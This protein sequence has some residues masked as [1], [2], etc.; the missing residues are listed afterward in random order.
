MEKTFA[1]VSGIRRKKIKS[2]ETISYAVGESVGPTQLLDASAN[3]HKL[4]PVP[5]TSNSYKLCN[6][7]YHGREL[8]NRPT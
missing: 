4:G 2:F 5:L 1:D 6:I 8:F 7:F 3:E